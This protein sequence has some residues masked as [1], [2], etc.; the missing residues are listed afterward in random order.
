MAVQIKKTVIGPLTATPGNPGVAF[1]SGDEAIA[2]VTL[3]SL[4]KDVVTRLALHGLSQKIGDSYAGA[5]SAERP[6]A[7]AVEAIKETIAQL[8]RGEW[9]VAAV[10]GGPRATLLARAIARATG[11]AL[12]SIMATLA[13]QEATLDEEGYKTL[14]KQLRADPAVKQAT[15]AIKLE[16]AAAEAEKAKGV[17]GES[18]LA[19]IFAP[20]AG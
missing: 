19:A 8:M 17:T 18:G 13:E 4:P 14:L 20:K 1:V 16:D 10:A 11:Q 3:E 15:A 2:A 7:Y 6:F 12:E 9:R 5:A